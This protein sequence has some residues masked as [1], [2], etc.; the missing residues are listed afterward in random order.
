MGRMKQ[1]LDELKQKN[2]LRKTFPIQKK[3]KSFIYIDGK[4]YTDFSSNDY[5]GLAHHE[6]IINASISATKLFGTGSSAS[7]LLSGTLEIHEQLEKDVAKFKGKED[8]IVFNSGYQANVGIIQTLLKKSDVIFSDKLNHASI[9]DGIQ[10]S[11]INFFRFKHNDINDLEKLLQK[12]R[13]NFKNALIITETVFSMD[14]DIA[15][16]PEIVRLKKQYDFEILI[17]EAH[18]T[19][20]F[21][22]NGAGLAEEFGLTNEIEYIMGTFSKGLGSFGAYLAC[23]K[24]TKNYLLNKCR[25]FIFSTAL[26]PAVICADIESLKIIKSEPERRQILLEKTQFLRDLLTKNNFNIAGETQIIPIMI[27]DTEK[28]VK[29]SNELK[30]K[31][32][33]IM[34]IRYPTVPANK[35][36]LRISLSSNHSQATLENLVKD[37]KII[38]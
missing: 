4:K 34:P 2:L 15:P 13:K 21:G 24:I 33:W 5:L 19:G 14:G 3:E 10:L 8:A 6:K 20:I 27:G 11:G 30:Q 9:I 26:P 37:L 28:A 22:K 25:S 23:S 12:H 31:G 7:R 18:S 38:L 17:D 36:R 32:Y 35:A 1:E 29:I 16:L